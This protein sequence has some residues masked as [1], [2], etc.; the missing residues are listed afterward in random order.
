MADEPATSTP[1]STRF[2]CDSDALSL[3]R[4][5]GTACLDVFDWPSLELVS[6]RSYAHSIAL[7]SV[8]VFYNIGNKVLTSTNQSELLF[9]L[10]DGQRRL[11]DQQVNSQRVRSCES[12][13][14]RDAR[15]FSSADGFGLETHLISFNFRFGMGWGW[16][17]EDK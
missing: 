7:L 5:S 4:L 11:F 9:V 13:E 8:S 12:C 1:T 10:D 17:E 3:Q 15:S 16:R 6:H 14:C 2:F